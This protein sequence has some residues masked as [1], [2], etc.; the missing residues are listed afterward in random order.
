MSSRQRQAVAGK[1]TPEQLLEHDPAWLEE[2]GLQLPAAELWDPEQGGLLEAIVRVGGCSAGMV[3]AEGLV[4]TNHHCVFSMLQEHSS[5]ERDLI[6]EGF[7]AESRDAELHGVNTRVTIPHRFTDVTAEIEVAVAKVTGDAE[8][9][10][11][12]DRRKKE[13]VAEC[14]AQPFRR[15]EV[16][17]DDDGVAYRLV[18][19]LEFPDVRLVYAPPRSVGDFGGEVDNWTW[20]RHCGDF[21]LVR[22]Y[23][24][25]EG[26]PAPHCESNR[27]YR[28]RRFLRIAHEGV[29]KGSFVMIAGYPGQTY[30][31]LVAAE[32]AERVERWF[33][34]R[35]K[36]LKEWHD[37]MVDAGEGDEE[38]RILLASRVK[39]LA[40]RE[41]NARGQVAA[42][43]RGRLI[44]KKLE[45]EREVTAWAAE[46]PEHAGAAE[47]YVELGRLVEVRAATWERDYLLGHVEY[48]PLV[49][50]LALRL[51]RWAIERQKPDLDRHPDYQERRRDQLLADQRREQKSLH[52]PTEAVL[53]Y[54]FLGHLAA[55]PE[56]QR[57][58]SIDR[59]LAGAGV[60]GALG[61][62][63]IFDLDARL[64]MFEES[65]EE[66]REHRDLLIDLALALNADIIAIEDAD[67]TIKG[68][69][70]RLR[71]LWRRA[72]RA[73]L[74][75]PI[76]PDANRTLRVSLAY[77]RGYR[78]HEEVWMEPRTRLA[79][80]VEKH[81]GEEPFD[82][83]PR[84]L[85]AAPKTAESRWAD[86]EL[87][88]VP[89]CF[90]ATGDTTGGSSGSP[91]LNGRGE[92]VG[93]NFDRVWENVANDFAYDP[94]VARNV[95]VDVRY[96]LW[97]LEE[98]EMPRSRALLEELGVAVS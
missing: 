10:R 72:L 17:V 98:V 79:G 61:D 51:T 2:L 42:T 7:L 67:H 93:V 80:M 69:V 89:V 46:Q 4:I 21:S 34:G 33:P 50:D 49:L 26:R 35:A 78:S 65:V 82:A 97:M 60:S 81:T 77:A 64:A 55:L 54:Y 94:A 1:W 68:A 39:T 44:E 63:K 41:K 24:D 8:R 48:G 12:T 87:G 43:L 66:L 71:P 90:L 57:L 95:A 59:L 76:D 23:A 52:P 83:A 9:Y 62:S 45:A 47:A 36:L 40:N 56:A 3:S 84:V 15:A 5:P 73:F 86:P 30:R 20:P 6:A 25:A 16:A 53:F 32:M 19:S 31:S 22:V 91:V 85:A 28:P 88:D 27:P 92:L 75:R 74:R 29:R 70:S 96:L 37:L 58:P 14:E 18:E 11:A 13:L 38:A